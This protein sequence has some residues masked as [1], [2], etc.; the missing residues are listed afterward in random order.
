MIQEKMI[1]ESGEEHLRPVSFTT[2]VEV[3]GKVE[4]LHILTCLS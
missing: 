1:Q 4:D 3:L 2:P